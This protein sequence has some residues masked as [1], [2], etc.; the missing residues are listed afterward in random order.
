LRATSCSIARPSRC[1]HTTRGHLDGKGLRPY[2]AGPDALLLNHQAVTLHLMPDAARPGQVRVAIEPPLTGVTL[3][4]QLTPQP[5]S[6][7]G[8][9]R[10]ALDLQIQPTSGWPRHGPVALAGARARPLSPELRHTD[11]A[12]AV[13]DR[14]MAQITPPGC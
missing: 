12:R 7:C 2:N 10:E 5:D 13:A 11:L 4:A 14:T 3:D 6:A 8:D 1:P 9:W